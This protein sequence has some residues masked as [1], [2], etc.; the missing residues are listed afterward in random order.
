VSDFFLSELRLVFG[1][2]RNQAALLVLAGPPLLIAIAVKVSASGPGQGAPDFF[3]SIT[4]NGLFVALAALTIEMGL[5]LPLATSLVAGD[6]VAGEAHSGTLR[7]LLTVP[8]SRTRLLLTKL[9]AIVAYVVTATLVVTVVGM[10]A[11]VILF[12]GGS[13]TT[14]SG[15]SLGGLAAVL[16]VLLAALYLA[17]GLC[18]L[19]AIG[20]FVSTLTEQPLAAMLATVVISTAS[21]VLDTIPQVAWL[22]PYL[23]T[24][25]WSAFAD[26]FRA[27]I[28]LTDIGHGLYLALAY[29]VVATLAALA[30][31]RGKDITS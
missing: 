6:A 21:F 22:H 23:V 25:Q 12:G 1:R 31:F 8:V 27:P 7:Y 24:H 30:R 17:V 20:L 10:V 3:S 26:L 11:G 15:T 28:A 5:F 14:I 29:G 13:M 18:S 4:Q 16:R 2:R 19:G 9:A